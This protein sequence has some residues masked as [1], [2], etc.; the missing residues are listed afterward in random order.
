[1]Q[2]LRTQAPEVPDH[3]RILQV[4]LRVSLLAVDKGWKLNGKREGKNPKIKFT[5]LMVS[6]IQFSSVAQ[7][8]P[9]LCDPM[10]HSTPGLWCL[11][12]LPII[13]FTDYHFEQDN[14]KIL[15]CKTLKWN[16]PST[17][18]W[19]DCLFLFIF[20]VL[21]GK[22]DHSHQVSAPQNAKLRLMI[23]VVIWPHKKILNTEKNVKGNPA[24][25]NRCSL[26][27]AL[28]RAFPQMPIYTE[29]LKSI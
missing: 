22:L 17:R 10:N 6:S 4:R 7:L 14:L 15:S 2:R 3:V 13:R 20:Q 5:G 23:I 8:C 21:Q 16:L 26:L 24:N 9:I 27:S 29:Y 25:P 18:F 11:N 1:M 12:S 19:A 28:P